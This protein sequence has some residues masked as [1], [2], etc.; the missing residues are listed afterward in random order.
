MPRI[1]AV[2]ARFAGSTLLGRFPTSGTTV[3]DKL[4]P[5]AQAVYRFNDRLLARAA[6]T[7]TI[8][9]PAYEDARPLA[10]FRY[11]PLGA[12][13]LDP[14]N[15]PYAGTLSI[16]QPATRALRRD[17]LRCLARVVC[18]RRQHHLARGLPEDHR[19]SDLPVF[20]DAGARGPQRHR[21]ADSESEQP[22]QRRPGR[23]QW[24][25]AERLPAVLLPAFAI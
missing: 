23:D 22:P 14:I 15:Y 7:R 11:D 25:R 1:R 6:V 18:P 10:N 2:E 12:A 3:Y 19:E 13:A 20:R 4:F 9:R 5:N 16:G 17:E 21:P 8:G 24:P